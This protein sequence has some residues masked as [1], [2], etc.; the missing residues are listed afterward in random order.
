MLCNKYLVVR[1]YDLQTQSSISDVDP[2]F[3]KIVV[4]FSLIGDNAYSRSAFWAQ[5]TLFIKSMFPIDIVY[6]HAM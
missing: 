3:V 5:G 6:E 1:A 4:S 2:S